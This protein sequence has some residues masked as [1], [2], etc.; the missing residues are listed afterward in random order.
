MNELRGEEERVRAVLI[1]APTQAGKTSKCFGV[2]GEKMDHTMKH[3]RILCLY[4]TQANSCSGAAQVKQRAST[5]ATFGDFAI[6][7]ADSTSDRAGNHMVIGYWNS[8]NTAKMLKIVARNTWDHIIIVHDECDSGNLR[9]VKDRLCFVRA[10]ERKA[11]RHSKS[12]LL[13]LFVTA[14]IGNLSKS[15]CRIAGDDVKKF[16]TGLVNDIVNARV[17]EHQYAEPARHYVGASWFVEE[18]NADVW[19]KLDFGPP[20][21]RK[22]GKQNGKNKNKDENKDEN[23]EKEE[24]ARK[25]E[26]IVL[27]NI[28]CLSYDAKELTL[29]VTST[30]TADH[31]RMAYQLTRCGYNVIVEVNNAT[32]R[33]YKVHFLSNENTINTW[34]IPFNAVYTAADKGC[35]EDIGIE[36][37]DVS[38]PHI[39]QAALFMNTRADHHRIRKNIEHGEYVKLA[40][41]HRV[42]R[43]PADF[44]TEPRV[45]LV[46]G[47]IAGRGITFQNPDIDFTC[48]SF[49]FA[50]THDAT[51]RGATNTQRFGRACGMLEHVFER[52]GRR[53]VLIATRA[54]VDA[55]VAN[56]EMVV[57]KAR[58][59]PNGTRIC[60][61]DLITEKEWRHIFTRVKK[62]HR[63]NDNEEKK[64]KQDDVSLVPLPLLPPPLQI[65]EEKEE[66]EN[67][68]VDGVDIAKFRGWRTGSGNRDRIVAKMVRYLYASENDRPVTFEEFKA[69][70]GYTGSD[71]QFLSNLCNGCGVSTSNGK[72]W[73]HKNRIIT[74]NPK[75][76]HIS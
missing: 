62:T 53:P 16:S 34:N 22:T 73:I 70:I 66:R 5:D 36:R 25:K 75:L 7:L 52:P 9:G 61:K 41:I 45:A 31:A 43:R 49:C 12:D 24:Y 19:K 64:K 30:R 20:P 40:A 29:V 2:I 21:G 65:R 67:E 54:I 42:M 71:A 57:Q 50:D 35:F 18:K 15:I 38:M 56:E 27:K 55:A 14:T 74:R 44:P 32:G 58:E 33:Q 76:V 8:R 10:V 6:Y 37:D 4:I 46:A 28:A 1:D 69:G 23:K 39:L 68:R 59:I 26:N 48:T 72:L 51:S 17:V 60:L 13:V 11:A 63:D 47:H 3:G